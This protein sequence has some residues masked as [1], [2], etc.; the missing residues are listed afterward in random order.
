M[1][2]HRRRRGG[3]TPWNPPPPRQDRRDRRG[4]KRNL[5]LG[6][7]GQALFGTQSFGTQTPLRILAGQLNPVPPCKAHCAPNP[8][9]LPPTMC[10]GGTR[11][12]LLGEC[13]KGDW[14]CWVLRGVTPV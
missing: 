1:A 2:V 6:K 11:G 5:P 9:P 7:S 3:T 12:G 10:F 8:M 13:G 4:A 14:G